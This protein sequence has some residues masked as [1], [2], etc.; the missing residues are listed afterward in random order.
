MLSLMPRKAPGWA[1]RRRL[2]E[3]E[4]DGDGGL[5]GKVI[6]IERDGAAEALGDLAVVGEQAVFAGVLVEEGRQDEA[7]EAAEVGGAPGHDDGVGEGG[8][9]DAGGASGRR[10]G[11][12]RRGLP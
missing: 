5:G 8:D 10:G 6:E 1:L 2:D 11:R 4:G 3:R 9:A 12:A 7:A